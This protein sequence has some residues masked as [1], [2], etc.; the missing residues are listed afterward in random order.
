MNKTIIY[1]DSLRN[2]VFKLLPM[3]EDSAEGVENHL[4]EYLGA[5]LVSSE[6]AIS[7]FS[8]LGKSKSYIFVLNNLN[9][10]SNH[11]NMQ[12]KDW[13]KII[14]SST[15]SLTNLIKKLNGG[16]DYGRKEK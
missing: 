8:E 12:F 6:G 1:L 3:K 10:I 2:D 13:R 4:G 9:Y 11:L 15:S 5:L 14:L 7:T 16:E